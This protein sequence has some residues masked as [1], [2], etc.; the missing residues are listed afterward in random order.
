MPENTHFLFVGGFAELIKTKKQ[1][2]LFL[3]SGTSLTESFT[4][5]EE[6]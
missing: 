2:A 5:Y 3:L 4:L 1:H 6:K